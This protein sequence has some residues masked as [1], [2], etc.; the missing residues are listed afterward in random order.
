M[1]RS[2]NGI[3]KRF[4]KDGKSWTWVIQYKDENAKRRTVKGFRDK[5][6]TM[7]LRAK[8]LTEV[9]QRRAGVFTARDQRLAAEQ[10]KPILDHLANFHADLLAK[11]VTDKHAYL[12]RSRA[13]KVTETARITEIGE[14]IPSKVQQ[15]IAIIRDS[16]RSLQT[17][18]HTIRAIKQFSR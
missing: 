1:S 11:G 5:G 13:S 12:V 4:S 18:N 16:G 3:Y 8:L 17:C 2:G 14:L 7:Q 6:A 15:A 10:D 9:A